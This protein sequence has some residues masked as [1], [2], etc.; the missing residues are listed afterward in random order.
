MPESSNIA[1]FTDAAPQYPP[2]ISINERADGMIAIHVRSDPVVGRCGS[3][4][5]IV[6]TADRFFSI[7]NDCVQWWAR[8]NAP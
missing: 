4:A 6:V 7:L 2:Y 1:A 8:R 3:E 5:A